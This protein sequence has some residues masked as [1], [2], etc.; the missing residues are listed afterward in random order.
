MAIYTWNPFFWS[1]TA[2]TQRAYSTTT[3]LNSTLSDYSLN[4]TSVYGPSDH[5]HPTSFLQEL[6]DTASGLIG[7]WVIIGDFNLIRSEDEKNNDNINNSLIRAFNDA[8]SQL[9]LMEIPLLGR[10]LT[11]TNGQESPVLAK[12]D[13]ALV[14]LEQ[15]TTSPTTSL[16]PQAKPTSDHTPILLSMH[17]TI[18]K[19][20][21]SRCNDAAGQL[22][23]CLK[24]TRAA[25]KVWSRRYRAPHHVVPNCKFLIKLFDAFEEERPLSTDELQARRFCH[26][27]LA[28]AVDKAAYWKQRSK[29]RA[30]KK[31]DANT[32]FHHAQ[33]TVR[34]R[35]NNILFVEVQ[36]TTI[37]NHDGKL[38]ALTD[39]FSTII[40]QPAGSSV[41]NF[42]VGSLS[43][44][45]I[46]LLVISRL[47]SPSRKHWKP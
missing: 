30:M 3:S 28:Q 39:Y 24:A 40:G 8:I 18:P 9:G 23:A 37:A 47:P 38:Q 16:I 14:N 17:T 36:G 10:S 2:F 12:L 44:I 4:V 27:S 11:W 20:Q 35:S 29:F 25:T 26:D 1:L 22:A 42:D 46:S 31:G 43:T 19:T 7:P 15:T 13:R 21:A 33:A 45:S 6:V 34:M 41:W 32:A 5:R